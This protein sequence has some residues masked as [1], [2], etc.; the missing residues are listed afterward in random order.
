MA[1][2]NTME[3]NYLVPLPWFRTNGQAVL[4]TVA[5]SVDIRMVKWYCFHGVLSY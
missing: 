5:V 3:N 1:R 2:K 4:L